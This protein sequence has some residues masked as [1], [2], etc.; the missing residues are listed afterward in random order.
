MFADEI[1]PQ[2]IERFMTCERDLRSLCV[3]IVVQLLILIG[4]LGDM[5]LS[6]IGELLR[7]YR[8]LA[9]YISSTHPKVEAGAS[10]TATRSN[11]I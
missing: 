10:L 3:Q 1:V 11:A 2:P 4:D 8:R 9:N 5:Q 6:E 7:D